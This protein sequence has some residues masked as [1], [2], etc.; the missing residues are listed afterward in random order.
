[1]SSLHAIRCNKFVLEIQDVVKVESVLASGCGGGYPGKLMINSERTRV[2]QSESGNCTIVLADD[3]MLTRK[4]TPFKEEWLPKA[5]RSSAQAIGG[6]GVEKTATATTRKSPPGMGWGLSRS[7]HLMLIRLF[8]QD[9][10]YSVRAW[11]GLRFPV[12]CENSSGSSPAKR[13]V[14]SIWPPVVGLMDLSVRGV[15]TSVRMS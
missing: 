13:F 3:P 8:Q 10:T 11:R 14:R 1:M 6:P 9:T 4:L 5:P 2:Y 7:N 15:G 12:V